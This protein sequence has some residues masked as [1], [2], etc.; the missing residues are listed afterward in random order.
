VLPLAFLLRM[1]SSST[2]LLASAPP[3]SS[4]GLTSQETRR[5]RELEKAIDRSLDTFLECGE[6]LLEIRTSRL[7]RSTHD[8]FSDY[9]RDR[10]GLSLS[11]TNQIIRSVEVVQIITNAFPQDATLL[12]ETGEHSLR[13]LSRL[14]PELQTAVWQLIRHLEER[15]VGT[16]IERVVS[17]IREAIAT[18]WQERATPSPATNGAPGRNGHHGTH[19][20]SDQLAS[21]SRWSRRIKTW[22]P[23]AIALGDDALTLRRHLK[24]ARVLR[25][26][27]EAFIQ[28]LESRLSE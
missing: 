3:T 13:P 6:A 4:G 25:T 9:C 8:R 23:E 20:R 2:L 19:R 5:L 7:Y 16:T 28:A 15:P 1:I 27:C 24:A 21:F 26:F 10:W 11:R 18:G 22:D 12:E 14:E 17:T